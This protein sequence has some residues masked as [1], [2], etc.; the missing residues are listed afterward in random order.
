MVSQTNTPS[1]LPR[2]T[3]FTL[4]V[5]ACLIPL[6]LH[7]WFVR[8]AFV[9]IFLWDEWDLFLGI[10]NKIEI[11]PAWHNRVF[12]MFAEFIITIP[13]YVFYWVGE[14]THYDTR[15]FVL[16]TLFTQTITFILMWGLVPQS[17]LT[18][19]LFN[20]S[21]VSALWF[22]PLTFDA[23]LRGS[24]WITYL[25]LF[26]IILALPWI[27]LSFASPSGHQQWQINKPLYWITICAVFSGL[28]GHFL[29][30]TGLFISFLDRSR[31]QL[32]ITWMITIATLIGITLWRFGRTGQADPLHLFYAPLK[33]IAYYLTYMGAVLGIP[34]L[35]RVSLFGVATDPI[36]L[37]AGLLILWGFF[38]VIQDAWKKK[39]FEAEYFMV[40]FVLFFGALTTLGR[41]QFPLSTATNSHY[42]PNKLLGLIGLWIWSRR[43]GWESKRKILTVGVTLAVVTH[44]LFSYSSAD[45]LRAQERQRRF[46]IIQYMVN[47]PELNE[48]E[49]K[50][51]LYPRPR[52]FEAKL[53]ILASKEIGIFNPTYQLPK[54]FEMP[55]N[56]TL[57]EMRT[58]WLNKNRRSP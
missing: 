10:K 14:R 32:R 43:I 4:G 36:L 11:G 27:T 17:S 5:L 31:H 45:F 25:S 24:E 46:W 16:I 54:D 44:I 15:Y 33:G 56:R 28:Q 41:S 8:G 6:L 51:T 30:L 12:I 37:I 20:F 3:L 39:S 29:A 13:A 52:M 40:I 19:K 42:L 57:K 38:T 18:K 35:P 55:L 1:R 9:N 49:I 50:G 48:D 26:F 34:F 58:Y 23:T 7:I 22:T 2:L 21:V 53:P 47:Y